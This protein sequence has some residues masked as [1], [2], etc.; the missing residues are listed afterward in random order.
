MEA[1]TEAT[2]TEAVHSATEPGTTEA[3]HSAAAHSAAAHAHSPASTSTPYQG[4]GAIC[5]GF[6]CL[7]ILRNGAGGNYRS[8][9]GQGERRDHSEDQMSHF[10]VQLTLCVL[11]LCLGQEDYGLSVHTAVKTIP[12]RTFWVKHRMS[13]K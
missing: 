8:G 11:N 4:E 7:G 9:Q 10:H 6:K 2:A 1:G 13:Q 3:A 12:N 5:L